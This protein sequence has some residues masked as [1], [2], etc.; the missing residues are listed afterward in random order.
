VPPADEPIE[1]KEAR[2]AD[3]CLGELRVLV[4]LAFARR[5][6]ARMRTRTIIQ[7]AAG[8][9]AV[10][11]PVASALAGGDGMPEAPRTD[12][13][14]PDAVYVVLYSIIFAVAIVVLGFKGS[15]RTRMN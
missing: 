15:R 4:A 5:I 1:E 6:I 3:A 2:T 13:Y 12:E 14:T 8:L 7:A 9:L 11:I 10:L